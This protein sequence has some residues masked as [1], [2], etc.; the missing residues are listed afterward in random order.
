MMAV[1]Y[2]VPGDGSLSSLVSVHPACFVVPERRGCADCVLIK[3]IQPRS[4][5]LLPSQAFLVTKQ[6]RSCG[7]KRSSSRDA[8]ETK[9]TSLMIE[10]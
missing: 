8:V 5:Y 1:P 10:L 6:C 2:P 3:I 4:G 9:L 7:V